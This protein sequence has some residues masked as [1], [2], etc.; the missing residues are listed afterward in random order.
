MRRPA[1]ARPNHGPARAL[2]PLAVLALVS[3]LAA[4]CGGDEDSE[5]DDDADTEQDT[6]VVALTEDEIAVALLQDDNLGEGWTSEPSGEDDTAGPGCFGDIDALTDGLAEKAKAGTEFAY[7]DAELPFVEST[8]TAYDDELAITGVFDQVQTVLAAC[9]T[10]SD[11]DD[12][13][14]TWDLAMTF[15]DAETYD[16]VDDQFQ[17]SASGSFTQPGRDAVDIYIEWTTVRLGPNVAT[18][19]TIDTQE[20]ADEHATWT[21]IAV[22]RLEAVAEGEE[23]EATTAPAPEGSAA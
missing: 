12:E 1:A 14:V 22:E 21:E 10:I 23:P 5:G 13:G 16:D 9:S 6:P 2:A 3:A 11:T 7:G 18:V 4:G 17:L 20:R 8:V 15:D 19:S